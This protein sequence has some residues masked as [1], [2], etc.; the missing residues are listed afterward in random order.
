[1]KRARALHLEEVEL[2]QHGL[3]LGPLDEAGA[4][5]VEDKGD[6]GRFREIQGD[7][8]RNMDGEHG[9]MRTLSKRQKARRSA[10]SE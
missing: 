7:G 10:A 6:S 2:K 4:V 5:L 1:M 8:W 3:H 9:C